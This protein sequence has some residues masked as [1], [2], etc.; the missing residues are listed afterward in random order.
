MKLSKLLRF[1]AAL[2]GVRGVRSTY[3]PRVGP[4]TLNTSARTGLSS[5]SVGTGPFRFKLW[6]RRGNTGLSSVD[7]PGP[8]SWRPSK[9][10][11]RPSAAQEA[12]AQNAPATMN[13]NGLQHR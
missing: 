4:L 13:P 1:G 12:R 2:A 10:Q 6:D 11:R 7:L 9:G 3:R 8:I 5:V